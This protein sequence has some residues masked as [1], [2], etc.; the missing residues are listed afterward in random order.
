[1]DN[2][3]L[4]FNVVLPLFL[5]ILLGYFLSR[6]TLMD[7]RTQKSLNKLCFR[8]FLPIYVFNSIYTTNI[9]EAFNPLLIAFTVIGILC[10]FASMMLLIPRIEKNP[11]SCGVMIQAVFRSNYALFGLPVA[12][13]LCGE[14][15]IGPASLLVGIVVPVY[16][17]LA[18]IC[19]E[20]FRGG[21]P[22]LRKVLRG[23]AANPLIIAS[24]LGIAANVLNLPLP[25]AVHK[26]VTDLGKIA[27]PLSLV[28]LGAGFKLRALQGRVKQLAIPLFFKLLFCPMVMLIL[29]T[30]LGL[31]GQTLV[32]VLVTFGSP[33]AVSSYTM[34]E[35]MDGDGPL[36]ASL[37]VLS[38]GL[39]ILSMFFFIF[40]LKQFG[41]V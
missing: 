33:V 5:C 32:P 25:A 6:T 18:V 22:N 19:L 15:G 1:M 17:I 34:A 40:F 10:I 9:S 35:Q 28:T 3:I 8:V 41:L 30:L 39:S 37:V 16:N 23:I 36:A 7:E 38:T 20:T 13:S 4:A 24:V 26:S 27:T 12:A 21:R 2:L 14:Q 11:A 29:G 31:R